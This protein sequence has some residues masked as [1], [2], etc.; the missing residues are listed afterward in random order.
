MNGVRQAIA[1]QM[2]STAA[3]QRRLRGTSWGIGSSSS[4]PLRDAALLSGFIVLACLLLPV[5]LV[6]RRWLAAWTRWLA[7]ARPLAGVAYRWPASV[8]APLLLDDEKEKEKRDDDDDRDDVSDD[9]SRGDEP[10]SA[11]GGG[12]EHVVVALEEDDDEK[13]RRLWAEEEA[14]LARVRRQQRRLSSKRRRWYS[15]WAILIV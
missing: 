3:K 7:G 10:F 12:K 14:A 15:R 6:P 11:V 5:L 13:E 2:A 9:M 1:F 4:H 8:T